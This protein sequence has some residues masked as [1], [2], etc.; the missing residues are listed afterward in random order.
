MSSRFLK[1]I[2]LAVSILSIGLGQDILN[3]NIK[4]QVIEKETGLPLIGA[5]IY[6][7]DSDPIIGAATDADGYYRFYDIP[8]GRYRLAVSYIGFESQVTG[9]LL[10][11]TGKE[12]I[13][14]FEL[15]ES[16]NSIEVEISAIK[17]TDVQSAGIATISVQEFNSQVTSRYAGS[18]NDV[19][20]MA[21]G[22]AGVS[23]NDDSR[24]DIVIRGNS[25][26]GLLWRMNGIDIPNPSHFGALGA[27]GGPVSML[28][29]NL[30]TNSIFMTGAF[31]ANY[32][33]ALSGVFD[34]TLRN[35]NRDKIEGIFGIGF[36]GFE[37]GLEG[38]LGNNGASYLVNYRYSVPALI[39]KVAGGGTGGTGTG[40]AI[41]NYQDL[42]F[43]V[44]VPT[45]KLGTFSFF[46]LGGLSGIE[47]ASDITQADDPNLFS[48]SNEDLN[49]KS[50]SQFI[51]LTNKHYYSDKS[52][53]KVSLSYARSG[54]NTVLDTISNDL[55]AVPFY[56]DDSGQ[57]RIRIA[58]DYKHKISKRHSFIAGVNYN[59]FEFN[60]QDSVRKDATSFRL[61]RDY[62]GNANLN[63][64]YAQWQYRHNDRLTL[65]AG[66][67]GQYYT[68]NNTNT[69][70]PRFNM[71]YDVSPNLKWSIGLG[72]HSKIQDF[73]LY[74]V[75]TTLDDGRSVRTNENLSYTTSDQAVMGLNWAF[76]ENWKVKT[77]VYYQSLSDVPVESHPSSFSALNLGA[78]FAV[79]ST[80]SLI[81]DGSGTNYGIELTLERSFSSGFYLLSTVSLFESQYTGSD[82]IEYHTAFSN[83]YIGNILSGKEFKIGDKSTLAVDL[84]ATYA[85]GR[86]YTPINLEASILE[87]EAVL[88]EDLAFT[89]KFDD[90]FRTDIKLTFRQNLKRISQS[91]SLD[92]QNAFNNENVFGQVY[93]ASNK[94]VEIVNQLGFYP[95]IE[96]RLTF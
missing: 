1:T 21:A 5:N 37:A 81:N 82:N 29:N 71:S 40:D 42:S 54:V 20:R 22:F 4:G 31:P 43:H 92:F 88:D 80:D 68:F 65:N 94:E 56:R 52:Y 36:N 45:K 41:P 96:Y 49:Y 90:Y 39:D 91:W 93:D 8:V 73:Q 15:V 51:A 78:D 72:R 9:S 13:S 26:S 86:R 6:I 64:A 35:G 48:D 14:N 63:Q 12:L 33:N 60:F 84:K 17:E 25:P 67:F 74:L 62:V 53:G 11:T 59:I 30:L 19:A 2:F 3:Q 24:N 23:A 76:S 28:N 10:L 50:N 66:I 16:M 38:P 95:V 27:T 77:E 58:Y 87:G 7:Q 57:D 18:R 61:L 75:E 79:P 34:L 83:G 32:G 85:G 89:K 44:H 69:I 46:G 47:F 55:T 70:E